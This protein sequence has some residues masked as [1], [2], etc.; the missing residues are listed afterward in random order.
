MSR[1]RL[2]LGPN[3]S[4]HAVIV[5]WN[6][7]KHTQHCV[8][9]LTNLGHPGLRE[10]I[11]VDNGSSDGSVEKLRRFAAG[12][13]LRVRIVANKKNLGYARG[14][15]RGMRVATKNG[16]DLVL[17]LNNDMAFEQPDF[18]DRMVRAFRVHP[19]LG[20]AGPLLLENGG[21]QGPFEER[22]R[23]TSLISKLVA[24]LY[25]REFPPTAPKGKQ[26]T[27]E[28]PASRFAYGVRGCCMMFRAKAL[29][30]VD[31]FDEATFLYYEE[32]LMAERLRARRWKT[33]F[34][35]D[36]EAFH[37]GEASTRRVDE[38]AILAM[39]I[40]SAMH[41]YGGVRGFTAQQL[42]QIV[43]LMRLG[44]DAA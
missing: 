11:V 5:N 16:A 24:R 30:E 21:Y 22:P 37:V 17:L 7:W 25:F 36:A 23:Y 31:Y 9:S 38:E 3:P 33:R 6:G 26:R 12:H 2:G 1:D 44:R 42:R 34:V 13:S 28:K 40:E 10:I 29:T 27:Q 43:M 41:Y 4:I 14:S 39:K 32:Y 20:L 18:L 35:A 19:R 8:E 15:N